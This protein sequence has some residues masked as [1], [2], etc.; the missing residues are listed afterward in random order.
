MDQA[1]PVPLLNPAQVPPL[2]P[3]ADEF[4]IPKPC[5]LAPERVD[6]YPSVFEVQEMDDDFADTIDQWVAENTAYDVAQLNMSESDNSYQYS[7]SVSPSTKVGGYVSWVQA[8][9]VPTCDTCGQA[10]EHLLSVA[11]LGGYGGGGSVRWYPL[12]ESHEDAMKGDGMSV[13]GD[14][15]YYTFV[16]RNCPDMPI[17]T[18]TQ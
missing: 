2:S 6:E 3:E 17:K 4:V 11:G 8:V 10:M 18:G 7:W 15:M 14:G 1:H 13:G 16:C 5:T 9:D 12:G